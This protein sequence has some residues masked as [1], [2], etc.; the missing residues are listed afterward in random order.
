MVRMLT[1]IVC[2]FMA[3]TT[4]V[5]AQSAD[6]EQ[7][8]IQGILLNDDGSP[9]PDGD[10]TITIRAYSSAQGG[11]SIGIID[12]GRLINQ[13]AGAFS[14]MVSLQPIADAIR[15][16]PVYIGISE[17]GKPEMLPRLRLGTVP[18]A[19][20]ATSAATTPGAVPIAGTS[21]YVGDPSKLP[22]SWMVAD[23]RALRASEY[24][25]L[26]AAIGT[27]F[28]D[29]SDDNDDATNFNLPDMLG[30]MNVATGE[31]RYIGPDMEPDMYGR[32]S[33]GS[34]NAAVSVGGT[35]RA[36]PVFYAHPII[37]VR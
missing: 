7:T 17:P 4:L 6:A 37:R 27:Y 35:R 23:G 25:E 18:K 12:D 14:I 36:I 33:F 30:T 24:P 8:T 9:R 34:T 32:W 3:F 28:G 2:T 22:S 21:S 11:E 20:H 16:G 19:L 29:G 13:Q 5:R 15:R 10:Y 31:H 26:F 1:I